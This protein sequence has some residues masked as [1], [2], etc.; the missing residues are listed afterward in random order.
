MYLFIF[1]RVRQGDLVLIFADICVAKA[2]WDE[3]DQLLLFVGD[4]T[5]TN[6]V[7]DEES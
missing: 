1:I 7:R 4:I 6:A 3:R 5:I 2:V